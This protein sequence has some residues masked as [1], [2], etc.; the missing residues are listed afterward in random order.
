[1][2]P[3]NEAARI[4]DILRA[5][6]AIDDHRRRGHA[7]GFTDD[8]PLLLDAVVRRLAVIG[9]AAAHLS[10]ETQARHRDIPWR[11]VTGMRLLLDH[12]YHRVDADIVWQT[13]ESDLPGLRD[14]LEGDRR[15]P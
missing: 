12:D 15:E 3:R 13:V 10:E 5:I 4:G 9:E 6:A 1:M 7:A 2:S 11:G 14:A 8:D